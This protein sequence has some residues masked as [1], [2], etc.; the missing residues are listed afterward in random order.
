M[1]YERKYKVTRQVGGNALF[2]SWD[3][4]T[5]GDFVVGELVSTYVDPTYNNTNYRIK[6]L[7]AGFKDGSQ[8]DYIG[9]TLVL[10][11]CAHLHKAVEEGIEIGNIIQVEY[12]GNDIVQT[13]KFAGRKVHTM[14][15]ALCEL[16]ED[17]DL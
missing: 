12:T 3:S 5:E 8:E 10:N 15:V 14:E 16:E 1:A 4:Y 11:G 13:G 6:V 17:L 2:R 9:K 7:E